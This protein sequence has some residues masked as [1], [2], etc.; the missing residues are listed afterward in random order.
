MVRGHQEV[1]PGPGVQVLQGAPQLSRWGRGVSA[2]PQPGECAREMPPC[3]SWPDGC[4]K[5]RQVA[6]DSPSDRI[7]PGLWLV[8]PPLKDGH[9]DMRGQRLCRE[10]QRHPP[11]GLDHRAPWGSEDRHPSP[12]DRHGLPAG[13]AGSPGQDH[14]WRAWAV[15]GPHAPFHSHQTLVTRGPEHLGPCVRE[16]AMDGGPHIGPVSP[17]ELESLQD[18][19]VHRAGE[20]GSANLQPPAQAKPWPLSVP[21]QQDLRV[22]GRKTGRHRGEMQGDS[23]RLD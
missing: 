21:Q 9:H 11:V 5:D 12:Q 7:A 3:S 20:A 16:P 8:G 6:P 2:V 15:G 22:C 13:V 14:H 4:P 18:V 23:P 17:R 10:L 19:P 1:V